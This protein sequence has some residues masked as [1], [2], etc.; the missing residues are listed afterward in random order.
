MLTKTNLTDMKVS[1]YVNHVAIIMLYLK[2]SIF[3]QLQICPYVVVRNSTA[4]FNGGILDNVIT[5]I[6]TLVKPRDKIFPSTHNLFMLP[7]D[8]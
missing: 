1:L 8:R 3:R 4:S 7:C 6:L 5:R 2:L